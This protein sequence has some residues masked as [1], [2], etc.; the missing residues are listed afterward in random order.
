MQT[1][2][3]VLALASLALP[4]TAPAGT[5]AEQRARLPPPA[6]C[7]DDLVQGIWKSHDYRAD[8]GDWVVFTLEVRRVDGTDELTGRIEQQSWDGN[9]TQSEPG[10]CEGGLHRIVEMDAVGSIVDGQISF[11]GVGQWR[12]VQHFCGPTGVGYNLDHF[13]GT[14]DTELL[15]FQSINNDGGRSVNEPTLFRRIG[16]LPE[17]ETAD[18]EPRRPKVRVSPPSFYPPRDEHGG[19]GCQAG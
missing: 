9:A 8:Y 1:M 2:L 7:D 4:R 17:D 12:L 6:Q 5:I 13:T 15:E 3:G 14:L 19:G 11:K 18:D 10:P 16:C